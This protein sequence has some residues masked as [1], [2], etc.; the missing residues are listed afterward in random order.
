MARAVASALVALLAT[1]A[2]AGAARGEHEVYYRYTVV[3]YVKDRNGKPLRDTTVHLTRDKTAY[4]YAEETDDKGFF[5]II[6][7]LGDESLGETLTVQVGTAR[8]RITTRFDVANR[9]EE[10]GTRLD[11]EGGRFIERPAWFRSTL[12]HVLGAPPR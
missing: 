3:G 2:G 7:R 5:M 8:T 4:R 6:T 1:L 9:T 12:T 10:R 11:L